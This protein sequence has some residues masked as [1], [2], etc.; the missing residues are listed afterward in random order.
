MTDSQL[1]QDIEQKLNQLI[2]TVETLPPNGRQQQ[3]QCVGYL[4]L[5]CLSVAM[6][7]RRPCV[8][9]FGLGCF[10]FIYLMRRRQ[11]TQTEG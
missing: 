3:Q 10:C 5:L 7:T 6:E 11:L 1:A 2:T 8:M 4:V 9:L